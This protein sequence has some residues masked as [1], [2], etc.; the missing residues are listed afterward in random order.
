[1]I[2]ADDLGF[3][4]R[5]SCVGYAV[6]A[7]SVPVKKGIYNGDRVSLEYKGARVLVSDV[8]CE[9]GCEG[10]YSGTICGFKHK[11]GR[12]FEELRVNQCISFH[13]KHIFSC[14][15]PVTHYEH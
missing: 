8:S 1:M 15:H 4:K 3:E 2:T 9:E 11:S 7:S 6:V 5:S 14:V 13:E 12:C 10:V